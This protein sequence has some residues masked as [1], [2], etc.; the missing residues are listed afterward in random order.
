LSTRSGS[1][2]TTRTTSGCAARR[3][4][5][6]PG[7]RRSRPQPMKP[8]ERRELPALRPRDV[9]EHLDRYVIGQDR[10]KRAVAIAAY[11]H[12]QRVSPKNYRHRG[13]IK[14][15]NVLLIGPTGSG[16]THIARN[17]AECLGVPFTI[18]DATE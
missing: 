18:V 17:L 8:L 5:P 4:S 15:S 16:K 1:C 11:N 14:K 2:S 3:S 12:L 7:W 13:L 6:S 9:Y 10:A